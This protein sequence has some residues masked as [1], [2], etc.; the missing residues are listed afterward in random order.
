M[1]NPPGVDPAPHPSRRE[2]MY[3]TTTNN[4]KVLTNEYKRTLRE[5]VI[6][7]DRVGEQ[8][9]EWLDIPDSVGTGAYDNTA[10][11][12]M[13]PADWRGARQRYTLM[14]GPGHKGMEP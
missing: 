6:N 13:G 11:G 2:R 8:E 5:A 3:L 10:H 7:R 14:D 12:W 4:A 9:L 1:N